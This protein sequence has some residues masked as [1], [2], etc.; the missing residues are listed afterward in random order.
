MVTLPCFA[1]IKTFC[2]LNSSGEVERIIDNNPVRDTFLTVPVEKVQPLYKALRLFDS[3]LYDPSNM[4]KFK[5]KPGN[6]SILH[7]S[8]IASFH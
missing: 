1:F 8:D 3:L 5:L 2:R 7:T 4:V 6:D